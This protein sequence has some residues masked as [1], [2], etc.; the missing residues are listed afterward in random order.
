MR[1]KLLL[2]LGAVLVAYGAYGFATIDRRADEAV[3]RELIGNA[4]DSVAR[5]DLGGAMYC[6][7]KDYKDDAGV[8]YDQL[9]MLAYQALQMEIKYVVDAPITSVR[10]NGEAATVEMNAKVT[11]ADR[12]EVVYD[13]FLTIHLERENGKHMRVIPAKVWRVRAIENLA[14]DRY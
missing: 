1:V 14:L 3:I 13:R 2:G 4:A 7:S 8:N 6:V 11:R 9:R 12:N 5:R 10:V